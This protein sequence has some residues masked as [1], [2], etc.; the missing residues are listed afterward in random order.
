MSVGKGGTLDGSSVTQARKFRT[1]EDLWCFYCGKVSKG[2]CVMSKAAGALRCSLV[3]TENTKV[4]SI[5]I[6]L[7]HKCSPVNYNDM[8]STLT[9]RGLD[10]PDFP[11]SRCFTTSSNELTGDVTHSFISD[12]RSA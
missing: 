6:I 5:H 7:I 1:A 8:G 9:T 12:L 2:E 4:K 11:R 3:R 10:Y